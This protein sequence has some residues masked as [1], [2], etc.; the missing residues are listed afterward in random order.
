MALDRNI[1]DGA[2]AAA[3]L[4]HPHP[5]FGGNRFHPFIDGLFQRLPPAGVAA[6]R[7]DFANDDPMATRSQ[8]VQAIDAAAGAVPGAPLALIGYSFGAGVAAGIA[9]DRVAA[10]FL[11]APQADGLARSALGTDPRPK[12]IVVPELDQ[13]T[14]PESIAPLVVGWPSTT[15]R[16]VPG[17]DHFLGTAEPVI[18]AA[19]TWIGGLMR[20]PGSA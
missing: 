5:H 4:L 13:F 15:L 19:V 7:F 9:D 12:A 6:F 1:P 10:W 2:R 14:P 18:D 8:A 11:L 20:A 17:M 3:V 16:T